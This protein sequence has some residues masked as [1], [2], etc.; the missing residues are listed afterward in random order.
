MNATRDTPARLLIQVP[1]L[2]CSHDSVTRTSLLQ[3]QGKWGVIMTPFS[4]ESTYKNYNNNNHVYST[5]IANV[6][7][8]TLHY[9]VLW[10]FGRQ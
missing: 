3:L 7:L 2:L 10:V 8:S 1:P 9:P 5:D 6:Y 4:G